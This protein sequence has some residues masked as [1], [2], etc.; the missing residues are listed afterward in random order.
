MDE[1]H[2]NTYLYHT[3]THKVHITFSGNTVVEG[4]NAHVTLGCASHLLVSYLQH[5]DGA[6]TEEYMADNLP[7]VK[8]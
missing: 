2:A 1:T 8:G 7:P 6:R 4:N 5:R 3:D